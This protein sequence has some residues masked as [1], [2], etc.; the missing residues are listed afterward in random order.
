VLG[1]RLT[2]IVL[3][4]GALVACRPDRS[5]IV[6]PRP[7]ASF[8][9]VVPAATAEATPAAVP[10]KTPR[11]QWNTFQAPDSEF[12]IDYP[13]DWVQDPDAPQY[14]TVEVDNGTNLYEKEMHVRRWGAD[15]PCSNANAG[16]I[17]E[18]PGPEQQRVW[19]GP[20]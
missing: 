18:S 2:V 4:L 10:T 13:T 8:V 20:C 19:S 6:P 7:T 16:G 5:A 1:R 15:R 9:E 14:F 17:E 11:V 3:S 12:T